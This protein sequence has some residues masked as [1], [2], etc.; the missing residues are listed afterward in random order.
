MERLF[1]F[2]GARCGVG[3]PA[4]KPVV[5]PAYLS[6]TPIVGQV[7]DLPE[8]NSDVVVNTQTIETTRTL[9]K[10]ARGGH[11]GG[12]AR[13]REPAGTMDGIAEVYLC[14]TAIWRP[15]L[16]QDHGGEISAEMAERRGGFGGRN[17]I[18]GLE[19]G[20]G[21]PRWWIL[22]VATQALSRFNPSRFNPGSTQ[23]GE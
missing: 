3:S 21:C 4:C 5:K 17:R 10:S 20:G 6:A 11:L 23:K 12:D 15:G 7:P 19:W 16:C 14:R 2:P 1:F 8:S 9:G 22:S 13:G 18:D